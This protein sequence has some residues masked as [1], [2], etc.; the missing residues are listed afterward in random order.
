MK[1]KKSSM[2]TLLIICG[3]IVLLTGGIVLSM[4]KRTILIKQPEIKGTPEVG[5]WYRITPEGTQSS[6][7][8]EW[9]GLIR[10]G[11]ENK[12]AVY[13]FGGGASITGYS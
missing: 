10:V 1:E 6:D 7:G 4:L 3:V 2:K 9:H 5:K 12:L 8:T 11:K 13:F